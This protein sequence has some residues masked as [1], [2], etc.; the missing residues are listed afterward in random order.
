[1]KKLLMIAFH[2]PPLAGSSGVQ[3]TL[4]L[5]RYLPRFGWEPLVLTAHTR[6]YERVSDDLIGEV[7]SGVVVERAFAVDSARHLSVLGRYPAFMALPDRWASWW[8]GAV[9]KGLSMIR[10]HRPDVIWSTYP[11]AT[12]H[13]IGHTLQ[14]LSGL[15]WIADFRDPMAQDGY[16][17]DPRAW[18]S[19][20]RIEEVSLRRAATS[21]FVAPGAARRYQERYPELTRGRIAVIENGYDE[22]SFAGLET[23]DMAPPPTG[24]LT[25]LHSGI[26][27]PSERDPTQLFQALRRMLDEDRLKPGELLVRLRAAVHETLLQKMIGKFGVGEVV[28]L[29]PPIPYRSALQEMMRA[30]GLLVLQAANCNDQIPAKLYEYLRCRRPILALT[31]PTGDTADLLRRSGVQNIARLD[32][33]EEIAIE[34]Q[35][36]LGQVRRGESR[37]PDE[38]FVAGAS[39]SRRTAELAE[40][41]K[42]VKGRRVTREAR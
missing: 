17:A 15:P 13:K 10:T 37:L 34:L 22:E 9:P 25:L 7:P 40:L 31:D 30:D 23:G 11:I 26:V 28:E 36:F 16:P 14:R 32:S 42:Q 12:A 18:L 33:A 19:F 2:F 5:V 3:R 39:R 21:V 6:A 29:A 20:K 41:L 24:T 1:M 38:A 4:G 35:R 8:L 27:Y